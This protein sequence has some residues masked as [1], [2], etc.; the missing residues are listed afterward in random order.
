MQ[1]TTQARNDVNKHNL[2]GAANTPKQVF[3]KNI[4]LS[5]RVCWVTALFSLETPTINDTVI[6]WISF[7]IILPTAVRL[8]C[9]KITCEFKV[10][11]AVS[12]VCQFLKTEK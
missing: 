5:V 10:C 4:L 9:D 7:G 1:S 2:S 3:D 12:H 6:V 8:S 11:G